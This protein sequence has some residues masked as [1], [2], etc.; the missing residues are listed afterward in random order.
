[1]ATDLPLP[2][3]GLFTRNWWV[4]LLRGI[5]AVIFGIIAFQAPIVTL[6]V[7]VLIFGIYALIDGI[8][9]LV[10]AVSGWGHRED[11]W[12]L[13]L[14]GLVGIGVGFLTLHATALTTIAL[15]FFVA[16]WALATG[17][18]KIIAAIRLRKEITNEFWLVLGGIASVLFAFLMMMNPAAGAVAMVWLLGW[19]ELFMGAM[20]IFLA[21]KMHGLHTR[22]IRGHIGEPEVRRAA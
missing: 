10:A 7:L 19:Y 16:M 22:R 20:M 13:V 21:I 12:L 18:L 8:F 15:L 14:E 6:S 1:M 5:F 4:L 3:L 2:V 17:I 11:R 9:A